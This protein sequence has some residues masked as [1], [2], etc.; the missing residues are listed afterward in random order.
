MQKEIKFQFKDLPYLT[1][2]AKEDKL[3]ATVNMYRRKFSMT[4]D[5]EYKIITDD[6]PINSN[7]VTGNSDGNVSESKPVSKRSKS[8][9]PKQE[10]SELFSVSDLL[11]IDAIPSDDVA[12][13]S[14]DSDSS[15]AE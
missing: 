7:P 6:E 5:H 15:I 14:T 2:T 12:N 9:K 3:E 4:Y 1:L 8:A 11:D 10:A 13:E